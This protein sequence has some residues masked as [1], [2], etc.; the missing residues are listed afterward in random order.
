MQPTGIRKSGSRPNRPRNRAGPGTSYKSLGYLKKGE[1]VTIYETKGNW[2][3]VN[4]SP[5]WWVS[6]TYV[7]ITSGQ[8]QPTKSSSGK[9]K[10]QNTKPSTSP[11]NNTKPE[12]LTVK[13]PDAKT[14]QAA[15]T[16]T[17]VTIAAVKLGS[18]IASA[19][20][21]K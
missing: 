18:A 12:P 17:K 20:K 1:A 19:L 14:V 13:V 15:K 21:K 3:K 9:K 11:G 2:Y 7:K 5:E 4:E 10:K 6:A 16:A 8:T